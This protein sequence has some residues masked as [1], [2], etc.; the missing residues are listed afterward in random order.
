MFK[1]GNVKKIEDEQRELEQ[2]EVYNDVRELPS[3][4]N[5][6]MYEWLT[7]QFNKYFP[8]D[9]KEDWIVKNGN[10]LLINA[11]TES[12]APQPPHQPIPLNKMKH[13]RWLKEANRYADEFEHFYRNAKL[14][15]AAL[16]RT[17][18][19]IAQNLEERGVGLRPVEI[20]HC[21]LDDLK[22]QMK[23]LMTLF[24]TLCENKISW[25]NI[26]SKVLGLPAGEVA[27]FEENTTKWEEAMLTFKKAY[28]EVL[29][30]ADIIKA[31]LADLARNAPRA[32]TMFTD[33]LDIVAIEEAEEPST[34]I[35][36]VTEDEYFPHED[37]PRKKKK[38]R[39]KKVSSLRKKFVPH[40]AIL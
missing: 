37:K 2:N 19:F 31:P 30:A 29:N 35:L 34:E 25:V 6:Q 22:D 17:V 33:G 39:K 3:H 9:Q 14:G 5:P 13:L 24:G 20:F 8:T 7:T 1:P 26:Q 4:R 15:V 38:K 18:K 12:S 27:W 16:P 10:E 36:D 21:S 40:Y 23:R 32:L 11:S 28:S